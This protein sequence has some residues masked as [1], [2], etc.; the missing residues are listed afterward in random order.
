MRTESVRRG[1]KMND[2]TPEIFYEKLFSPMEAGH[3]KGERTLLEKLSDYFQLGGESDV[4]AALVKRVAPEQVMIWLLDEAGP[5]VGMLKEIYHFLADVKATI[6]GRADQLSFVFKNIDQRVSFPLDSFPKTYV[7]A[8]TDVTVM[9]TRFD[10]SARG[11]LLGDTPNYWSDDVPAL[12]NFSHS[13]ILHPD[14]FG[15]LPH[16]YQEAIRSRIRTALR[17][18]ES[19]YVTFDVPEKINAWALSHYKRLYVAEQ[20]LVDEMLRLNEA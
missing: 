8:L 10:P 6:F 13:F 12:N 20:A 1:V 16:E 11:Y 17:V 14:Q 19:H 5:F 4:R 2:M 15:P 7:S 9:S 18:L 3:R